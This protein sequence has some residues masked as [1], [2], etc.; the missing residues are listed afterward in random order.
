MVFFH[1][2]PKMGE[3]LS[4]GWVNKFLD[5]PFSLGDILE[6]AQTYCGQK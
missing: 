6:C 1:N 5:K 3:Y 4:N 2:K